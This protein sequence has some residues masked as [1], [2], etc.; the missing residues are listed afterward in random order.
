MGSVRAKSKLR[1]RNLPIDLLSSVFAFCFALTVVGAE[2]AITLNEK[3]VHLGVPDRPEWEEF[4]SD[5]AQPGRFEIRF[6]AVANARE[7]TLFIRQCDV[8]QEWRVEINRKRVGVLSPMEAD[9][10]QTIVVPPNILTTGENVLAIIPSLEPDDILLH[11]II[12]DDRPRSEAHDA[13]LSVRISSTD[14]APLPARI[15]IADANGVLVPVIAAS[16]KGEETQ[17]LAVRPGVAYTST[18]EARLRVR[19]GRYTVFAS[20]GF[21]YGVASQEVECTAGEPREVHLRI[22]RQVPTPGLVSCDPHLHTFT[23]SRH[24]DATLDE[25]MVTLAGEAIEFPIAT[26]H[27]LHVDYEEAARRLNVRRFFTPV[28]GNEVTTRTG[29]FNVFPVDPSAPPP[30]ANETDWPRLITAIRGT[31][32]VQ[33]IILNHPRS[34]HSGFRPFDPRNF[35]SA[36]G[37]NKRGF[38]FTFNALEVLNSG[39]QQTDYLLVY[40]DWFA[41]LN[42]GYRIVAVGGSDSHDVSRFVVGQARTYIAAADDDPGAIDID[43][44]CKNLLRGR[45]SISMG[46]LADMSVQGKFGLGDLATALPDD[47]V[48]KVK[49]SFPAWSHAASVALYA[50]GT[51]IRDQNIL[52]SRGSGAY[53]VAWNMPKPRHDVHLVAIA[54]GPA[55]TAPFWAMTK[56]YQPT[57][58]NWEGRA[59]ASTNPIWIDADG[60][61]TFT[62]ARKYAEQLI[63]QHGADAARLLPALSRYDEA[64]ATQAASLCARAGVK[65][66]EAPFVDALKVA[67]PQVAAGFA[68]YHAAVAAGNVTAK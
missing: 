41:L 43:A 37:E 58:P 54:T 28:T 9:L 33:V 68:N 59:I 3:R 52:S 53:E 14:G 26:D 39:A 50:N 66:N 16:S 22:E 5:P 29:H 67:A 31:S 15:T 11:E 13:T 25:R 56:P 35:N 32:G 55:V 6:N 19:S 42:Y 10:I 20:R 7:A 63:E 65:L 4:A 17:H 38:E 64:V 45:A 2:H 1:P 51:K 44:A 24:G 30:D 48:V 61:G 27:N 21:E 12:L 36:T 49:L 62:A 18:G 57:S 23:R 46:L 40:R 60:D 8:K 34:I 47:I